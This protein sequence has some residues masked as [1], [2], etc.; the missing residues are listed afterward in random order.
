MSRAK[1]PG[2]GGHSHRAPGRGAG[3]CPEHGTTCRGLASCSGYSYL[4]EL[5]YLPI[6]AA[7]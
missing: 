4:P 2:H 7:R 6:R 3:R 1:R 5:A